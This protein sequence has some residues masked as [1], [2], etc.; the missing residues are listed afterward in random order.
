M[1][2]APVNSDRRLLSLFWGGPRHRRRWSWGFESQPKLCLETRRELASIRRGARSGKMPSMR[3]VSGTM[4]RAS[5]GLARWRRSSPAPA[6]SWPGT[7]VIVVTGR[8][9]RRPDGAHRRLGSGATPSRAAHQQSPSNVG[10][11]DAPAAAPPEPVRHRAA[12]PAFPAVPWRSVQAARDSG[13]AAEWPLAQGDV[14]CSQWLY[15]GLGCTLPRSSWSRYRKTA[16]PALTA[17]RVAHLSA[18]G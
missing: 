15:C 11:A 8:R 12:C 7:A 9:R 3:S 2:Q 16:S 6:V 5:R 4:G 14:S 13:P 10:G 17:P 18:S 1:R